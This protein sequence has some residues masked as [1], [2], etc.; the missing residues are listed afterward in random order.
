MPEPTDLSYCAGEVRRL[1]H[2]R[3]LTALFA[4]A[5]RREA[6]FALYAF[7]IEVSKIREVVSDPMIGAIRLQWWRE[8]IDEI[9]GRKPVRRHGVAEPLSAA[10]RSHGLGRENFDRLIDARAFDLDDDP[11]EDVGG[12][13][14][15]AEATSSTLVWLALDILGVTGCETAREVGRKTGIAWA[16]VGLLRAAP[17]HLRQ[18]RIYIPKDVA[19]RHGVDRRSMLDLKPSAQLAGAVSELASV[20]AG[21]LR[22]ARDLRQDFPSRGVPAVLLAALADGYLRRLK[23][24]RY[25]V[26]DPRLALGPGLNTARLAFR[27]S[28]GRY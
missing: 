19:D 28:L 2:D 5:D 22:E 12:L 3:F 26:F 6:L 20:A 17:A 8:V 4:P 1:D 21:Q 11:P 24:A 27:A 15:Y 7:N 10:I 9:F 16:I 25:N 18:G 14:G 23:R 13:S